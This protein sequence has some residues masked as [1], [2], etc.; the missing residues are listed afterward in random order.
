MSFVT[1]F[2]YLHVC[3]N[4][5]ICVC[6]Q[7]ATDLEKQLELLESENQRL[8]QELKASNAHEPPATCS[9]SA[10]PH[11]QVQ[12]LYT[13]HSQ[14]SLWTRALCHSLLLLLLRY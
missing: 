7:G 6:A 1:L 4:E 3:M 5:P 9:S 12:F 14:E 8:K 13:Q 2:T 11:S 10:C